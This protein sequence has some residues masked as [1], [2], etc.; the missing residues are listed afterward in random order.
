MKIAY[1][2]GYAE[3]DSH[4]SVTR[5]LEGQISAWRKWGHEVRLFQLTPQL[6]Q[7]CSGLQRQICF[8][9]GSW[10]QGRKVLEE[11]KVMNPD[12]LYSRYFLYNRA[13]VSLV[14]MFPSVLEVNSDD[15]AE[16]RQSSIGVR[17]V[18][19]LTR[20]EVYRGF[21]ALVV[22]TEELG[23]RVGREEQ[24]RMCLGNGIADADISGSPVPNNPFPVIGFI[25]SEGAY[26]HGLDE[27]AFFAER[28]PDFEFRVIGQ[29]LTKKLPNVRCL[30]AMPH[31]DAAGELAKCDLAFSTMGLYRKRMDEACPLKS[32]QY[33]ALGL[34][35]VIGY[36]DP[37][38][39]DDL[40]FVLRV[41]N[42]PGGLLESETEVVSFILRAKG[43]DAWRRQ[44]TAFAQDVL[45][46]SRKEKLRLSFLESVVQ[47][48]TSATVH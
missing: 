24:R 9:S 44:A 14:R 6:K 42:R 30:G 12:V 31:R 43:N 40:E 5:K 7:E 13:L 19:R 36:K 3:G 28:H 47:S 17:W 2:A 33:L 20:D 38:L 48:A 10:Q 29:P 26:W 32:R 35:V 4:S 37:D 21:D 11:V 16:Y 41:P 1:L 27:L 39:G 25:G 34:P 18:N 45:S 15:L 22:V 46:N 23:R 8:Y